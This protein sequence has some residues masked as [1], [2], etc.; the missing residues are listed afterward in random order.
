MLDANVLIRAHADYYPI[1]RIPQFWNWLLAQ[2]VG[3]HA[4]IPLEIYEEITSGRDVLAQWMKERS[5]RDALLLGDDVTAA[6]V[7]RVIDEAYAP[8]ISDTELEQA[9]C[10]PF[11]IACAL[12]APNR[13]VVTK[14]VSKPSQRRG[15]RKVPDACNDLGVR[16]MSD[17]EFYQ[18]RDFRIS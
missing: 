11:L 15:R 16:W 5:T 14:E 9:G 12:A 10:D 1:D 18:R 8:D 6:F 4:K 3:G 7:N 17:F 2:G 13:C